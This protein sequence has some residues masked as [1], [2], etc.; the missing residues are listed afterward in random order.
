VFN[1]IAWKACED[2]ALQLEAH[3]PERFHYQPTNWSKFSD[4]GMD[5]IQVGG[6]HPVNVISKSHVLFLASFDNNDA[7]LSQFH[8]L[9]MLSESFIRTLTI[10][11]PF[12]PMG[13]MERVTREGH[14]ATANTISRMLSQLPQIGW[15]IRIMI[16]DL[17]TLQ[18]RFYFHSSTIASLHTSIPLL[19]RNVLSKPEYNFTA[20]AFPDEGACKRFGCNFD[21]YELVTCA[22]KRIGD[23]RQVVIHDGDVK[24]KHVLIVDDIVKTGG[25]LAECAA[26]LLKAGA[27]EVSAFCVHAAFP[28]EAVARFCRG[29]D[30]AVF[31][32]FFVTNSNRPVSSLLPKDDC[33]QVLDLVPQIIDDLDWEGAPPASG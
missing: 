4:S 9:T 30:R 2:M 25:T 18:N 17:H 22:K 7:I 14:V 19:H 31:K 23:S 12:F 6:F 5:N 26:T 3:D 24:D 32:H 33:F 1:V 21:G 29:G 27:S 28:P 13:T 8:V 15:P 11:L 16:Y 20:I 10:V